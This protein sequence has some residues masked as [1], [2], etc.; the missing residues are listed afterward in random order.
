VAG[1]ACGAFVGPAGQL[2]GISLLPLLDLLG[3]LFLNALKM[4]V[5]PLASASI[6]T[7]VAGVGSGAELGRL[8]MKALLFY[9]LTTLLA[10]LVA[11]GLVDLVQPGIAGGQPAR[12]LL[13]LEGDA[14]R[15]AADVQARASGSVLG[16]LQSIVPE[17][18]FEAAASGNMLG[19]MFFSVLFGYF[20]A[21]LELPHRQVMLGFWQALLSIMMRITEL[22]MRLA[23]VGIFAL[24]ARA[25][26]RA[27]LHAAVPI[28][29]FAA[30]V[31]VGIA[32]YALVVLP[33][34][35][36]VMGVNR[37]YRLFSALGPAMLTAFSTASSA[38][39]LGVSLECLQTRTRVS[40][41]VSSFV[42]PLG[43]SLNH[44]GSALY[45]CSAALFLC[46]A[47]GVQLTVGVQLSVAFLALV[48]SMGVATIPAASLVTVALILSAVGLPV[49]AIG[50]LMVVE[51]V[52][53]MLR[54]SL[55]V[56]AD[57]AC[58]VLVARMEGEN[59][60]L[61]PA[62]LPIVPSTTR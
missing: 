46:Q 25:I 20:L 26:A 35:L 30:C 45:E 27:G 47:Y 60:T 15:I 19:V 3:N 1:A 2:G 49:K 4:V 33:L 34:L 32:L 48:S 8:G 7:G 13:A 39:A 38:A 5:V 28:L 17:N 62:S 56:F 12:A 55:N 11:V 10:V 6:I 52:L 57:G 53:D 31:I 58:A 22:V 29:S 43:A 16:I 51:R 21:R 24:T 40:Q 59:D 42:M 18:V 50:V 54:T 44:V 36:S 37:P 23:P 14:A 41:R 9:V 61:G